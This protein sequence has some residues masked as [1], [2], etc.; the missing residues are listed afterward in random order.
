[1]YQKYQIKVLVCAVQR[2]DQVFIPSGNFT[3]EAKDNGNGT[4]YGVFRNRIEERNKK[5]EITF[6][7]DVVYIYRFL[8]LKFPTLRG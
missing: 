5:E 4:F 3:F 6:E 1:M 2:N 8:D 7:L